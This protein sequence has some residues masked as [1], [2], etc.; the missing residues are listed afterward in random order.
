[1]STLKTS[2]PKPQEKS[3]L[4]QISEYKHPEMIERLKRKH[5]LSHEE[6]KQLFED[7]LLFLFLCTVTKK[8]VSPSPM[9]DIGWHEFLMYT[10]DYQEF[11]R[12]HFGKFIHHTPTPTLGVQPMEKEVLSS[13]ETKKLALKFFGEVSDNWTAT[14]NAECCPEFDCH[15]DDSC[16]GDV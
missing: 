2:T 8:P 4:D 1:M 6:A 12:V 14:K 13:K 15:G 16:G 11:C 7:T 10:R 9:I 3:V 5:D